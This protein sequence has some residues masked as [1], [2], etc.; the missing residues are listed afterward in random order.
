M[1]PN[2]RNAIGEVCYNVSLDAFDDSLRAY[3][4][5]PRRVS[6]VV[7]EFLKCQWSETK[8]EVIEEWNGCQDSW[9]WPTVHE[10]DLEKWSS[11]HHCVWVGW[12]IPALYIPF[13]EMTMRSSREVDVNKGQCV[14]SCLAEPLNSSSVSKAFKVVYKADITGKKK[15]FALHSPD[16]TGICEAVSVPG[17][18]PN[19]L[20]F[21]EWRDD[22]ATGLT[23]RRKVWGKKLAE[24]L[25]ARMADSPLESPTLLQHSGRERQNVDDESSMVEESSDHDDSH[26]SDVDYLAN[27]ESSESEEISEPNLIDTKLKTS[28]D[29]EEGENEERHIDEDG[30]KDVRAPQPAPPYA[31]SLDQ[32]PMETAMYTRLVAGEKASDIPVVTYQDI[33]DTPNRLMVTLR[34]PK[35][36][37]QRARRT[38][39]LHT[40]P[41]TMANTNRA[42]TRACKRWIPQLADFG[43]GPRPKRIRPSQQASTGLKTD[44]RD[45]KDEISV[46]TEEKHDS[47][48]EVQF[49][50]EMRLSQGQQINIPIAKPPTSP[51]SESA[52]FILDFIAADKI[53]KVARLQD[54]F[55]RRATLKA[56]RQHLKSTSEAE[57]DALAHNIAENEDKV[58][59]VMLAETLVA[60]LKEK[61][62][63]VIKPYSGSA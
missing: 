18:I 40:V 47:D 53:V 43:P 25:S 36:A 57:S 7:S 17:G 24:L 56:F 8:S 51:P 59:R 3:H 44:N 50:G 41:T 2:H 10:T 27:S 5:R 14:N 39:D 20:F 61:I 4:Q 60:D 9:H 21:S 42:G 34:V 33:S 48:D 49:I 54:A 45:A 62:T 23:N 1:A 58:T 6:L 28:E 16:E 38:R 32:L 29:E 19:V 13:S 22:A 52:A 26:V 37:R 55:S 12:F 15:L 11:D 46:K 63:G 30:F 35:T 31:P